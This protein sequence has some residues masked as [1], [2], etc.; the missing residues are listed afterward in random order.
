MKERKRRLHHQVI[1]NRYR[2]WAKIRATPN[3]LI[4][5]FIHKIYISSRKK[6]KEGNK[7]PQKTVHIQGDSVLHYTVLAGQIENVEKLLTHGMRVQHQSA[8]D[9][10][11]PLHRA[12]Q[13]GNIEIAKVLINH[14]ADLNAPNYLGQ[15]SLHVALESN[16]IEFAKF[17]ST[18]G[19]RKKCKHN[20]MRCQT[21]ND[22][23]QKTKQENQ[24]KKRRGRRNNKYERET[25]CEPNQITQD[26]L[27]DH[28]VVECEH[29]NRNLHQ[30]HK[31]PEPELICRDLRYVNLDNILAKTAQIVQNDGALEDEDVDDI[32]LS[33]EIKKEK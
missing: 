24:Q 30:V 25:A 6:S 20:C 17:M 9:G 15:T 4:S 26:E 5:K 13:V 14:G 18:K 23:L 33:D 8:A 27:Q 31:A 16:H 12:A 22:S 19:A 7:Q 3:L 1:R 21:F 10:A 11:T 28:M 32:N 29:Q 2:S